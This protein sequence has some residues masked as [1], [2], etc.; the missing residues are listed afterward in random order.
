MY[1]GP[2]EYVHYKGERYV[3]LGLATN[4]SNESTSDEQLVIYQRK[5]DYGGPRF[6]RPLKEF[7][8]EVPTNNLVDHPRGRVP[9][10]RRID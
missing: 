7:D 4:A 5:G 2:G 9:R 8:Q 6:A 1:T 3:A 10:F